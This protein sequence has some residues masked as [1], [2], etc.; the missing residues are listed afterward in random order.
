MR[1][2]SGAWTFASDCSFISFSVSFNNDSVRKQLAHLCV[3][4]HNGV[5]VNSIGRRRVSE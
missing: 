4:G 5:V 3:S 2:Y 1:N